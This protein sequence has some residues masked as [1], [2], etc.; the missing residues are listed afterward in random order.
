MKLGEPGHSADWNRRYDTKNTVAPFSFTYGGKS[1]SDFLA[2][3]KRSSGPLKQNEHGTS[4][5][6]TYADPD[7]GLE[8]RWEGKEYTEYDTVEWTL[9]FKNTGRN[10]TPILENIQA[11][12]TT[13]HRKPGSEY[14]LHRIRG[15]VGSPKSYEPLEHPLDRVEKHSWIAWQFH[16]PDLG[17]G[18]AQ[19]FRREDSSFFGVS[20]KLKKLVPDARYEVTEFA[21]GRTTRATGRELMDKGHP[22][23]ID[24]RPGA[25]M[26]AY[27]RIDES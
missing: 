12:D 2:S 4:R 26:I 7:G 22:V 27:K 14:V 23:E 20:L 13:F 25:A 6:M 21:S 8:V 5:T 11:L 15:D 24:E 1:S 16:R 18:M 10:D 17:R 19:A 3:W 9:Y